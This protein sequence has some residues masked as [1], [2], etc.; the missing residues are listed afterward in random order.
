MIRFI[1]QNWWRR[2]ERFILLILGAFILSA[3]LT[4]LIGLSETNK[5]TIVDTLQQEWSASYDIVVR[6]EGSR[7]VTEDKNLLEP[8]YLSGL[9]G[10]ISMDQYVTIKNIQGIEVAAPIAMIG[11]GFHNVRIAEAELSEPGIYRKT[12]KRLVN[13]GMD[14]LEEDSVYYFPYGVDWDYYNKIGYGAGAPSLEVDAY[15]IPLLAGID[16]VEE[17]KLV[18]LDQAIVSLGSSRYCNAS[19]NTYYNK[20]GDYLEIPIIVNNQAFI[21]IENIVSFDR[22][23]LPISRE[24]AEDVMESVKE[25]GGAAYLDG[26]DGINSET[27]TFIGEEVFH[28][29]ISEMTG[30]DW[31]TGEIE[32]DVSKTD[33]SLEESII[34][35][36]YKPSPLNYQA[37]KSPFSD[38]WPFAYQ[39]VPIQNGEESIFE[40]EET[41]RDPQLH[42][43]DN[44]ALSPRVKANW[45][46]FYDAGNLNISLDPKSE[47]PMETYR[48][49]SAELVIDHEGEPLNPPKQLKPTDEA[50]DFLTEPPAMLTTLEAAAEILGDE[51]ISALRIKVAGVADLSDESQ[52]IL[53][54]IAGEIEE[55][56]GLITDI[57][58]G[59]SPQLALSYVPGINEGTATGWLQQPWVNIGSSISIFREVKLGFAG[60]VASVIAVA[61]VYVWSSGIISLL[62]RRKEFAVLLSVGWRPGQ[63]SRLLFL[64]SLIVVVFVAMI[65]WLLLGL[66]YMSGAATLPLWRFFLTGFF[67]FIVYLLGAILPAILARRI[68]PYEAMQTGE[69]TKT[70]RR[71][72]GTRGILSMAF[73]N[74]MGKWK[75]SF[76]SVFS[77]SLPKALLALFLY[78]TF[79]LKGFIINILLGEF[80][81]F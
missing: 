34:Y 37:V 24:T 80:I 55:K 59:S 41:Y 44:P 16:P 42:F 9:H 78:I 71:I 14:I 4:Y 1:W 2:K 53:E 46:G 7:S 76:L 81:Y 54:R 65:S 8:N 5:G 67:G 13:N 61:V 12:S 51:P 18:G 72:L 77:I 62:A 17:A 23:D 25:K 58:L 74:Y 3:G 50:F 19:D 64:E 33:E 15:S 32:E 11:Y 39:V 70:S 60:L 68:S 69:I 43:E 79:R 66:V 73:N 29:F 6:P 21:D 47:L 75:R 27:F 26:F 48:P 57:T 31:E 22:L 40:G 52:E 30:V 56:T 38:R 20:A 10:G 45:I 35:I 36:P 49:A 28:Q 63:L